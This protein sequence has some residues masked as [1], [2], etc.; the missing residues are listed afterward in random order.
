MFG[1][2]N[3]ETPRSRREFLMRAG[4]G[5][6]ALAFASLLQ[7]STSAKPVA[8]HF[9][10][11]AKSVIWC[12]IDGGPSH[13]DLFDPKPELNRLA[14]S[15]LPDSFRRPVTAMGK[16]AF[17]NLLATKRTF[18]QHGQSGAWVS[19]WYPEIAKCMDD[20]AVLRGCHADGLNH[21][22]SV[23][24][25]NTGSVLAGRPSLGAW[26][27]Y[28]LGS[29]NEELPS[30]VVLQDYADEPP[31]GNRNWGTGFMPAAHQGTRFLSGATPVLHLAPDRPSLPDRQRRRL[32]FLKQLNASHLAGREED[33]LLEARIASYELAHRMQTAAPEA[34]DLSAETEET[35]RV[36]G[37]DQEQTDANARN[38]L[39]ARRLVE[40]GVRFV[41]LYFGSG[42]KWDAHGN[43]EGNHGRY[44]LESDRPIAG[45]LHDLKR[46]G[47]LDTTLVIW[48]GEF[49]RTPMSESGDGRDH[50]P[51]GFT[52]WMAGGGIRGG[53]TYGATDEI[54]LYAIEGRAHVHDLHATILHCLGLEHDRLTFPH[55]GRDERATINGG[56]VIREVIA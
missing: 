42:S 38:C 35:L 1:C 8:P 44:C 37:V 14:G 19:D 36:Y 51:Y 11:R 28:G 16:T 12:F 18:R 7:R 4:G 31:G 39:L 53:V 29:E 49:G 13:I 24:Q 21:V 45:L 52:M 9:T 54:G 23:C 41:Q 25:M 48:G 20:I 10:P 33:D 47:L 22:G 30:F 46:R 3:R 55:N 43:V 17:T 26:S 5:C 56:R 50:N 34:V 15:P 27:V 32:D 40:R 2:Q 6:G